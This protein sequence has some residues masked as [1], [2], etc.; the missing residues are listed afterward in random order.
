MHVPNPGQL[1]FLQG[2]AAI[3]SAK[4]RAELGYVPA[5]GFEDGMAVTS[6]YLRDVYLR[7]G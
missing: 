6:R 1:S 5:F 2:R 7:D 3:S 4:A